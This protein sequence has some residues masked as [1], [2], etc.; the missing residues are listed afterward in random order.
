MCETWG[1]RDRQT[2]QGCVLPP[3]LPWWWRQYAPLKLWSALTRLHGAISQ[4]AIIFILQIILLLLYVP[5]IVYRNWVRT[6]CILSLVPVIWRSNT[7]CFQAC[8]NCLLYIQNFSN[9]SALIV[10]SHVQTRPRWWTFKGDKNLQ[11]TFLR[12]GSKARGPFCKIL[13]HVKDP[14]RYFRCWKAKFSLLHSFLLLVPDVP[15]GGTAREL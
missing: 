5:Y 7:S 4:K 9:I 13:L 10:V 3:S 14:L 1:S 11:H 15:A 8:L 2:F 12:M 6:F